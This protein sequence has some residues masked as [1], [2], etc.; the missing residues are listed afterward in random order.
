MLYMDKN[1]A[2]SFMVVF[3]SERSCSAD[4]KTDQDFENPFRNKE[5]IAD[6]RLHVC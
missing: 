5:I 1:W 3:S 4:I 6:L 2:I